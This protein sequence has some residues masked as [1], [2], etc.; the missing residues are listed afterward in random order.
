MTGKL[1]T[2]ALMITALAG[3]AAMPSAA[4]ELLS[5][6]GGDS[7]LGAVDRGRD[8]FTRQQLQSDLRAAQNR[9]IVREGRRPS[10]L[11]IGLDNPRSDGFADFRNL[12]SEIR[13]LERLERTLGTRIDARRD[14]ASTRVETRVTQPAQR[15]PFPGAASFA[16]PP[17]LAGVDVPDG[18]P[19]PDVRAF[20]N[21][22][23]RA[24]EDRGG[25]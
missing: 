11:A 4:S 3:G 21:R 22:L 10:Q 14:D 5:R 6:I 13:R 25:F 1:P 18:A 20:V 16:V 7:S 24:N 17:A 9:R 19:P 23:L 2:V 15:P 8:A 12:E